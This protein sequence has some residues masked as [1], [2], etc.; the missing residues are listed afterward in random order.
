MGIL[1]LLFDICIREPKLK[2]KFY[3]NEDDNHMPAGRLF[4][5]ADGKFPHGGMFDRLKGALSVYAASKELGRPF[6]ILF[7]SPFMLEKYL[8]PNKYDWR[9]KEGEYSENK[10]TS[11]LVFMY[12]E[13]SS[14]YRLLKKRRKDAHIYYGYNSLDY[15]NHKY[16]GNHVWG[17]LYH[18]LFQP[19]PYLQQYINEE[20]NKINGDYIAIHLRFMN[21][22]GD[23]TEFERDP[24][25]PDDEKDNLKKASLQE[26]KKIIADNHNCKI[27]LATDSESFADFV[28]HKLDFVYMVPGE[29]KHI[30]TAV[31]TSD[32]ANLK[33]FLDYYMMA[34]AKRIFNIVGPGMWK[35]AFPEYAAKI[36]DCPFERIYI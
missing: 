15:I 25:L 21:L 18:E 3:H 13:F 28:K 34:G 32:A 7:T 33:M 36:G 30:G 19:T 20:K 4:F 14:P 10:K 29:I 6:R 5:V 9:V 35:S 26:I 16:G 24:T 17:Q 2:R 1:T 31:D 8:Q 23:K 11:T 27:M 12:G 22:L